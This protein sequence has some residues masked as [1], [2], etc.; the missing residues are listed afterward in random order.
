MSASL[1]PPPSKMMSKISWLLRPTMAR[2]KI[3][4]K[5]LAKHLGK[6]P[7]T[8]A[9]LKAQDIL[10]EIGGDAIEQIRSAISELSQEEFGVCRLSE[11]IIFEE[12]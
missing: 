10:P 5:A 9:R 4:N 3:T 7:T 11:L 12:D 1:L 6:H 8:I 2:R